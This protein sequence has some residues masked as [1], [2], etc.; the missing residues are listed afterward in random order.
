MSQIPL[1]PQSKSGI[2]YLRQGFSLITKP[3]IRL[4]VAIPLLINVVIFSGFMWLLGSQFSSYMDQLLN[5][6]PEWLDFIRW[7]M[8]PLFIVLLLATVGY[9]FSTVANILASPFNGLL[10]EKVEELL[11]GKEVK[12]RET[13]A[14]ALLSF[15]RSIFREIQKLS[16]Y[17]LRLILVLIL[18]F[19]I[20]PAAPFLSFA[21][22]A[23]MMGLNYTDFA[24]DNNK[25]SFKE[26]KQHIGKKRWD[27]FG[28]GSFVMIG[29]MIPIVNL[30]IMPAAVCGATAFW[31]EQ[32]KPASRL[33]SSKP[34]PTATTTEG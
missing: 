32:I 34:S 17:L 19:I 22:G 9:L 11:T 29:T 23:W 27:A 4:Y 15:P 18:G 7:I 5:W 31:V 3:G 14:L 33:A 24:M 6:L 8:W 30:L 13:I 10:A 1:T 20:A 2:S 12:G 26:A 16:Y 21:L 25:L 28:F